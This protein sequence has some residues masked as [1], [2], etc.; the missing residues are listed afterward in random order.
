V[1]SRYSKQKGLFFFLSAVHSCIAV[2]DGKRDILSLYMMGL[3][4]II[5]FFSIACGSQARKMSAE[6]KQ[7]K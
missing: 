2:F 5:V 6:A 4:L 3:F 1:Q 7:E